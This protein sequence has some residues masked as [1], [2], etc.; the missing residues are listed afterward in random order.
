MPLPRPPLHQHRSGSAFRHK[1]SLL[2]VAASLLIAA[3]SQHVPTYDELLAEA[4]QATAQGAHATA[5]VELKAAVDMQPRNADT[6]IL[7]ARSLLA[8]GQAND[9]EKQLRRAF[10]LGADQQQVLP[11]LCQTLFE[12]KSF[13]QLI[14]ETELAAGSGTL[15]AASQVY[16]G[17]ALLMQ[18]DADQAEQLFKRAQATPA[19]KGPA[20]IGLA[21]VELLRG[22][23]DKTLKLINDVLAQ[24]PD[25]AEA[26]SVRADVYTMLQQS[27]EAINSYRNLL[28]YNPKEISAYVRLVDLLAVAKRYSE[29][30]AEADKAKP[31]IKADG[32]NDYL[33]AIILFRENKLADARKQIAKANQQL[34]Q[35]VPAITLAGQIEL[36]DQAATTASGYFQQ[37]LNIE[38]GN[39]YTRMLLAQAQMMMHEPQQAV[40]TLKPALL[41][42]PY[43]V[44]LYTLAGEAMLSA[45]DDQ[46]A[47]SV[48]QYAAKLAP[49][50]ARV[51]RSLAF[52]R[53][54][55]GDTSAALATFS[56]DS[57][58]A[59]QTRVLVKVIQAIQNR[60][61]AEAEQ[62]ARGLVSDTPDHPLPHNLL[63]VALA[64]QQKWDAARAE[65]GKALDIKPDH[66]P[67]LVN[68]AKLDLQSGK[69]EAATG[70]FDTLLKRQPDNSAL[71]VGRAEVGLQAGENANQVEPLLLRAV[72]A[73]PHALQ[74]VLMLAQ[75]HAQAGNT[76]QALDYARKAR[77]I[78]PNDRDILRTLGLAELTGGDR[79]AAVTALTQWSAAAPN[80]INALIYL[81][82]AQA[83]DNRAASAEQ[84][85]TKALQ[86]DPKQIQA[87]IE[88]ALLYAR[89]KRPADA[90]RKLAD[91]KALKLSGDRLR[92]LQGDVEMAAGKPAAAVEQYQALFNASASAGV[93]AK[94]HD[95]L[96][97][98]GKV[99]AAIALGQQWV[100]Q[101]ATDTGAKYFLADAASR[102]G[103]AGI[104]AQYY[105]SIL[106]ARPN[107]LTALNNAAQ[108]YSTTDP[109]RSLEL[110][111]RAVKLSPDNPYVLD[112]Y[113]WALLQNGKLAAA[114]S[115]IEQAFR[116]A[117]NQ[118]E[119]TYH[120]AVALLKSGDRTS[121]RQRLD[122]L[123]QSNPNFPGIGDARYLQQQLSKEATE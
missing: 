104:A 29:A 22:N 91:L 11:L 52:S 5:L 67:A 38:P 101:H 77:N 20:S 31:Y 30:R 10:Q 95:A 50:N 14:E 62:L 100:S 89:T 56:N 90:S 75:M 85:L 15:D 49:D 42:A 51:Q 65:F 63:G 76:A 103:R 21:Q 80:D 44:P 18:G 4:A 2:A 73:N 114:I 92:E 88:L 98:T 113:G 118:P 13:Q 57:K 112:T 58:A 119:I 69:A 55:A 106:E 109:K 61:T 35:S 23:V 16:R 28:K 9:A 86:L 96:V 39:T 54:A 43:S 71:L 37:A 53:V 72:K 6:R 32:M 3:C 27:D 48:L 40:D 79:A 111:Q 36:A 120:Y 87:H 121:A 24:H 105:E 41:A 78:A 123:L 74:P 70:R 107:D 8:N 45:G 99:D 34:T 33:A 82:R 94:L 102:A 46:Q 116:K 12:Q 81:A 115:N 1:Q 25:N 60:R 108:A 117:G 47:I 83:N 122:D 59:L 26:W 68:L 84:S 110:A 17:R 66:L 93:L 64:Q 19:S 7:L 97:Q